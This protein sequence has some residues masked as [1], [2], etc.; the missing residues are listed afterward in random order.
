MT[1]NTTGS[2]EPDSEKHADDANV[3]GGVQDSSDAAAGASST[4]H[5]AGHGVVGGAGAPSTS[6]NAAHS[7]EWSSDVPPRPASPYVAPNVSSPMPMVPPAAHGVSAHQH[8]PSGPGAGTA[9]AAP[10]FGAPTQPTGSA[11]R[12]SDHQAFHPYASTAPSGDAP[13]D[14]RDAFGN[15]IFGAV[16]SAPARTTTKR[17]GSTM[18]VAGLAIGALVGGASG[19]GAFALMNGLQS[20]TSVSSTATGTQNVTIN[21]TE[22]VNR[23]TAVAAKAS[24]S[25]VTIAVA[26]SDGSGTGSGIVLSEDGYILTNNH[27]VTLDGSASDPTIQVTDNN[28]KIYS[29]TI[30]G[31][32]P[33]FDLAVIKLDGA[34]GMTKM[35]FADSSKLNVGDNVVAIGAPLGLSGTVTDGIISALNRSITVASSAVPDTTDGED[36][37]DSGDTWGF[38]IPGQD[39]GGTQATASISLPVVQTDA[40]INPGNSGGA[41]VNDDGELIGVNV[42]IASAGGS[43]SSEQ[44][45]SIGVGFAIPSSIAE[46][47][48]N[49]IIK[50]GSATHGLLGATVGDSSSVEG[51]TVAGAVIN[52]VSTNGAAEKAGIRSGD[53]ITSFNGVPITGAT[54][55]TAQ[56]RALAAG[57][58]AS[59]VFQRDGKEYTVDVTLGEL[60]L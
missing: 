45:G 6:E 46:R 20:P 22:S 55:L 57:S 43:S 37:S 30:V 19:A 59:V 36:G 14:T 34:S 48:A 15:P 11:G 52:E 12:P 8:G 24:P 50:D 33:V 60:V 47:I 42:A 26:G 23:T 51:S 44:S 27:V 18:L 39:S 2:H 54:D 5:A 17:R 3:S 13:R 9:G 28:G 21:D 1:E 56:V 4:E 16:P 31:T 32:D 38:E 35:E 29:A 40:A 49:E 25:V 53:V 7:R 58:T 41:L 10:A